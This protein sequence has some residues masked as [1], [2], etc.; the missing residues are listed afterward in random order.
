MLSCAMAKYG[1]M[2]RFRERKGKL[3]GYAVVLVN[4]KSIKHSM[5]IFSVGLFVVCLVLFG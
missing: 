5:C 4:G 2:I 3:A 1:H